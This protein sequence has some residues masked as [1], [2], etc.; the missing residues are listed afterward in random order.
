MRQGRT[1]G[2]LLFLVYIKLTL[3]ADD[4]TV[5]IRDNNIENLTS[6]CNTVLELLNGWSIKNRLATNFDE[7]DFIIISNREYEV[8]DFSLSIDQKPIQSVKDYNFLGFLIDDKLYFRTYRNKV[9]SKM[10][11]SAGLRYKIQNSLPL[12]TSLSYYYYF[13]HPNLS[14]NTAKAHGCILKPFNT[15]QKR[16]IRTIDGAPYR[17]HTYPFFKYST[18]KLNEIF[19]LCSMNSNV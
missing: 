19:Y 8:D 13:L 15:A 6:K 16:I 12:E 18:L 11:K 9:L 4:T 1:I 17:E 14:Y 2:P 3:F 7:T 5:A 10:S